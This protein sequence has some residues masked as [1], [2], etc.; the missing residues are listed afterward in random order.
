MNRQEEERCSEGWNWRR[1]EGRAWVSSW[2]LSDLRKRVII[3]LEA[4][5]TFYHFL[6]CFFLYFCHSCFLSATLPLS[7]LPLCLLYSFLS[8]SFFFTAFPPFLPASLSPSFALCGSIDGGQK[9]CLTFVEINDWNI[10]TAS[11]RERDGA[12]A[13]E[14]VD[15]REKETE[16]KAMSLNEKQNKG[17]MER[18][19]KTIRLEKKEKREWEWGERV[20]EAREWWNWRIKMKER[21]KLITTGSDWCVPTCVC[22]CVFNNEWICTYVVSVYWQRGSHRLVQATRVLNSF[23]FDRKRKWIFFSSFM[24]E[25]IA[26]KDVNSL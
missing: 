2:L 17:A 11:L 24:L 22:V 16:I 1:K 5:C 13:R 14:R 23:L 25:H 18:W 4:L 6:Y 12:G 8:A 9:H 26:G 20:Q 21:W 19:W 15:M 10:N 7:Y 3:T